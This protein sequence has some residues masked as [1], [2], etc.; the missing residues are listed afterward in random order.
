M[1]NFTFTTLPYRVL[2]GEGKLTQLRSEVERLE[3]HRAL[4]ISTHNHRHLANQV[5]SLAGNYS[6]GVFSEAVM[7]TPLD[8][9]LKALELAK[10]IECDGVIAIGGGSTIGLAKA[11]AVRLDCP[12]IAIP[13]TYAGSEMTPVLGETEN[14]IKTTRREPKILPQTVIYDVNLSH[15][16][17]VNI[18][19]TSGLNAIAHAVEALYSADANPITSLY[20]TQGIQAFIEALPI[21]NKDPDNLEARSKA[22]YGAWLCGTCLAQAGMGIHHKL[23]HILGGSFG[24]PHAETHSIILS[25]AIAYNQTTATTAMLTVAKLF[26]ETNASNAVYDFAQS[27]QAPSSLRDLGMPESGIVK[28]AALATQNSYPNPRALDTTAIEQLLRR[29]W[30]G[31]PPQP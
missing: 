12:Q 24:L 21:I 13:T 1:D 19:I 27:L 26:G 5:S 28:A 17:P 18:S 20:A 4:V 25:H 15:K 10:T 8:V 23:C 29:A 9:T 11:I 22:L 30:A 14:G 3:I 16:L 2:F 7:H 6:A 31:E